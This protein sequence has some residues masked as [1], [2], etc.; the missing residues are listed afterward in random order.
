MLAKVP[1]NQGPSLTV[2]Q[3]H[4]RLLIPVNALLVIVIGAGAIALIN[5]GSQVALETILGLGLGAFTTAFFCCITCVTLRKLSKKPLLPSRF[6][7]G[8]S[9]IL[10][11]FYALSWLIVVFVFSF[12]PPAPA[13]LLTLETMNWSAVMWT[14]VVTFSLLYF[15][16]V[17]RKSYV[18]PI[19]YVRQLE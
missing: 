10:V 4:L 1:T 7:L 14:G 17:G 2:S 8:R 16:F 18:G 19:A 13:R 11:N 3:V 12:F 15:A 5:I 6:D 9:G